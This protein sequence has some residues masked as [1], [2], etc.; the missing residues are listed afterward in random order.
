MNTATNP[1]DDREKRMKFLAEPMANL[2]GRFLDWGREHTSPL[3]PN[4]PHGLLVEA[5]AMLDMIEGR[6]DTLRTVAENVVH[7]PRVE[8]APP[9]PEGLADAVIATMELAPEPEPEPAK[10]RIGRNEAIQRIKAGLKKRTGMTWSVTGGRGT[11]YGWIEIDAPPKRRI[12]HT[13]RK[14]GTDGLSSEDYEEIID[15]TRPYGHMTAADRKILADALGLDR[16]V[17]HQGQSIPASNDY[18]LEYVDRAEGRTPRAI[19][20][21]Y[22][23]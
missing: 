22:W 11:A 15:P 5:S 14:E 20:T 23:D 10:E 12:A 1:T 19:G 8:K 17:H 3:D 18:Y 9:M 6:G 16:E 4:S 13:R 21:P 2:L 7:F